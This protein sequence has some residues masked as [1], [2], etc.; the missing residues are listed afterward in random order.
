LKPKRVQIL[1]FELAGVVEETG[2]GVERLQS[3]DE[4]YAYTGLEF[5][6]YAEYICLPEEGDEKLGLVA[7][8]PA[9][10]SFEEAAAVPIGALAALN[11]LRKGKITRG[12]D[13]LVIGASGSVGTYAVQL[14]RYFG[15]QVDGVCSTRNIELIKSLGA[16]QV[17][18]YARE[19]FTKLDRKYDLI[20]D[21]AG[22]LISGIS[23][24]KA[25]SSLKPGGKFVSVEMN[26]K[27][28]V[29]DLDHLTKLI[30]DGHTTPI[31]D[32]SYSLD[33]IVEAHHYVEGGHKRGNV[34]VTVS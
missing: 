32:R 5:G 2:K 31:I 16:D 28:R 4:V 7:T 6:A 9:N 34:V 27:D 18:D 1:G 13:V 29:E 21:A 12:Q 20:F 33:Q 25:S 11:M 22:K 19:D 23:K 15:T 17:I 30:E 10:L 8:K 14:A 26:R 3:G 24:S